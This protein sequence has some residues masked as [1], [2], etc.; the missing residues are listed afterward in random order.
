MKPVAGVLNALPGADLDAALRKCCGSTRWVESMRECT[1]FADDDEVF[2]TADRVWEALG[3][4]DWLEAFAHHPRIGDRIPPAPADRDHDDTPTSADWAQKEQA[5]MDS[6]V[7]E[8]RERLLRGNQEYEE[9]FGHVF[10]ICA[11]GRSAESML[12][13]LE[14]RI[15]HDADTELR[16]AAVEQA[17]ITR[18]R[19]KKLAD[20]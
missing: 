20:A 10:L 17:K 14:E 6:A 18:L 5:G 9:R 1:P 19:L 4:E 7:A 11:T 8:V 16:I 12:A 15:L 2:T 13:A 3:P